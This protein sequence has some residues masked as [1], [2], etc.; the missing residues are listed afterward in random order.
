MKIRNKNYAHTD[1]QCVLNFKT[2]I[3]LILITDC[4][5]NT[6]NLLNIKTELQVVRLQ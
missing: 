6:L 2:Y 4:R 1:Y 5:V 3:Y